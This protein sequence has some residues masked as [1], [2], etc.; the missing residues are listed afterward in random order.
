MTTS[1][2][3]LAFRLAVRA[4]RVGV[5][6]LGVLAPRRLRPRWVEEWHAEIGHA[7]ARAGAGAWP[8]LKVLRFAAGAVPDLAGL[9][10]L[11]RVRQ[12]A[13]RQPFAHAIVQDLRYAVRDLGSAPSFAAT[14]VAS[15]SIGVAATAGAFA[16]I[17]ASLFPSQPGVTD[18]D[19]AVRIT[20][21]RRCESRRCWIGASLLS[22]YEVVRDGLPRLDGVA[23]LTATPLAIASRGQVLS[24]RGT[25]VTANYFDVLGVR[26]VHGRMFTSAEGQPSAPAVAVIGYDL[27]QRV[28]GG[29]PSAVGEII[30]VGGHEVR[31]VGVA[32]RR[33]GQ[34]GAQ[35]WLPF[36]V[37]DRIGTPEVR[38][39]AGDRFDLDYVARLSASATLAQASAD[40][41]VAG[42]RLAAARGYPPAEVIATVMP[43]GRRDLSG[44]ADEVAVVLLIPFSVLIIG[45][46]NAANLL[47][48]RAT[49]RARDTA[50]RLALGASRWRIVR[51]LLLESV[52]L[53][54]L[55]VA[56]TLPLLAWLFQA[57]ESVVPFEVTVS[58]RVVVFAIVVA[59]ASVLIFGLV[60]GL[61]M[62]RPAGNGVLDSLRSVDVPSRSRLR[63]GLVVA[64]VAMSLGLLATGGQLITAAKQLAGVTG[65]LDP[66]R[67]LMVS[68][69]VEQLRMPPAAAEQFYAR[70]L[71]DVQRLPGVERAGLARETALWTFGR[72]S[73]RG[74]VFWPPDAASRMGRVALGG[75]AGGD[76]FAAVGL[77]LQQG[78]DFL[79]AE[80]SGPPRVAIVSRAFAAQYFNGQAVG[81]TLRVGARSQSRDA[82]R[83]VEIVGVVGS[84]L[85]PNY[86][87]T[88]DAEQ[89][90]IYLPSALE[91]ELA[92]TLYVRIRPAAGEILPAIR[93]A[94]DAADPRVPFGATG[95]LA[96]RRHERQT[97]ERL[98]AQGVAVLGILALALASGGLYGIVSFIATTKRREI[99]VR[100][101][102]GADPNAIL[103]LVAMRGMKMALIGCTI[104][105]AI[106]LILSAILRASMFSIAP[107][108]L[109]AFAGTA[110][111]LVL[112][113]FVASLVPAR[114]AARVDPVIVLRD[115]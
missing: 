78:R 100:M 48:A 29:D 99:G 89:Q 101:A 65:A 93:R 16:V 102:L 53:A 113:M 50:V 1:P 86:M 15:L 49:R 40:A 42:A 81:R 28:Y 76:L 90:S 61:R 63:Q 11:P 88:A 35:I 110:A 41:Q 19:R 84:T 108:D 37:A 59:L 27:W 5:T 21:E 13:T 115:E 87:R 26:P 14:V 38:S 8:V 83:D 34:W 3:S 67:L 6:V 92:L 109:T 73:S 23:A 107:L 71:D 31:V 33:F 75:L 66:P 79:P 32:P 55:S 43:L 22:D 112:S 103:K 70:V 47:L 82:A 68:F 69:D 85:D 58:S 97:D 30:L 20:F 44:I 7:A 98:G 12:P 105:G 52:L 57:M 25:L 10:R 95:T 114:A 36:G 77:P 51:Q 46:I 9:Y 106:A 74:V 96:E 17:S 4:I 111:I 94:V 62:S 39:A 80:R 64:Q 18:P 45:C 56:A 91:P 54:L 24:T 60:P 104:G 72:G 2:R